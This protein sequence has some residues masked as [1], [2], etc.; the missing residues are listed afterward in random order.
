MNK[1]ILFVTIMC[2][3]ITLISF[4][5][6]KKNGGSYEQTDMAEMEPTTEESKAEYEDGS[7]N[8][9]HSES[10]EGDYDNEF[11]DEKSESN[12]NN[13]KLIKTVNVR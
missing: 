9:A 10:T 5:C 8:F 4:G 3:L 6:A 13:E 12:V 1:K 7:A 2:M 11:Q